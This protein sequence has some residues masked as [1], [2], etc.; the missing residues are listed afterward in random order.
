MSG[1]MAT[2]ADGTVLSREIEAPVRVPGWVYFDAEYLLFFN[3]SNKLPPL[4]TSGPP[5]DLSATAVLGQP[6]TAVLFGDSAIDGGN[7][8]G[9]RFRLGYWLDAEQSCAIEGTGF[10]LDD[11]GTSFAV[12][13]DGS[14]ILGRPYRNADL[15]FVPNE[16]ALSLVVPTQYTGGA[17]VATFNKVWG[18]EINGR[19]NLTG[20]SRCR[21][22]MLVGFRYAR[23][24]EGTSIA[25]VTTALPLGTVE[26]EGG[27][28]PAPASVAVQD[29]F[30]TRNEF[31]GGQVGAL[32]ELQRGIWFADFRATLAAGVVHQTLT[33]DGSTTLV[34]PGSST[35]VPGGLLAQRTN[36]GRRSQDEFGLVPE[37]GVSVGCQ[38][39]RNLR[40]Y[41][42]Y[43]VLYWR[44]DVLRP[45][46]EIDQGVN[47]SQIPTLSPA[48][49]GTELR[50]AVLLRNVDFWVQGIHF[51]VE[52]GF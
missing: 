20:N 1:T 46:T 43:S 32:I 35:T 40:A 26:F 37:I 7:R 31:Y 22:D 2:A 16:T 18:A 51:G 50:P 19:L 9:A 34:T 5:G 44:N 8:S 38:I 11:L 28:V 13:S 47:A 49:L 17:S 21:G 45:G 42:G 39:S 29:V 4:I 15:R 41:V 12:A 14:T 25:N 33:I 27:L 23:L 6:G 52:L 30:R 3:K 10:Y 24:E 36:M 48:P